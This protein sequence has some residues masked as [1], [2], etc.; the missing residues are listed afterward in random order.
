MGP[1]RGETSLFIL[2]GFDFQVTRALVTNFHLPQSTLLFDQLQKVQE[3]RDQM[4][5]LLA[6]RKFADARQVEKLAM[7][8][9]GFELG[10]PAPCSNT[11]FWQKVAA[12]RNDEGFAR[13]AFCRNEAGNAELYLPQSGFSSEPRP[14]IQLGGKTVTGLLAFDF[15]PVGKNKTMEAV[16]IGMTPDGGTISIQLSERAAR[17]MIPITGGTVAFPQRLAEEMTCAP[18]EAAH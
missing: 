9:L 4:T 15:T 1:G 3:L 11:S 16:R 12:L 17:A 10:G 18:I 5:D 7:R 13:I 6:E 14:R 2:P 8:L